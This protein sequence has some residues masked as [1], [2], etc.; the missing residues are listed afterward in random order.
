MQ[1]WKW[2]SL[3]GRNSLLP[4]NLPLTAFDYAR[5]GRAELPIERW[6]AKRRYDANWIRELARKQG[7]WAHIPPKRD[8]KDPI[9]FSPSLYRA[10]NLTERLLDKIKQCRRVATGYDKLGSQLSGV[11]QT[12]INPNLAMR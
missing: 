1:V 7:A 3:F 10:R 8:R 9:C 5:P 2:T 6:L 4:N 11:G 12:R